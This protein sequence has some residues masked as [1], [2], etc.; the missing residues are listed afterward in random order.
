MKVFGTEYYLFTSTPWMSIEMLEK[1]IRYS[2]I[3]QKFQTFLRIDLLSW[4]HNNFQSHL[5][6]S[7][8]YIRKKVFDPFN[9]VDFL[10]ISKEKSIWYCLRNEELKNE[11]LQVKDSLS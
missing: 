9:R 2:S 8:G 4:K 3:R 5:K 11:H 1:L 6:N 7:P 10:K